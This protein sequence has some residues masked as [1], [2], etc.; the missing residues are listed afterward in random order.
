M[1]SFQSPIN[2]IRA[3]LNGVSR[4]LGRCRLAPITYALQIFNYVRSG[5]STV[6]SFYCQLSLILQHAR[7]SFLVRA[8]RGEFSTGLAFIKDEV[9]AKP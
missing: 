1:R 8:L 5:V 9:E 2:N 7:A 3:R 4:A 6:A